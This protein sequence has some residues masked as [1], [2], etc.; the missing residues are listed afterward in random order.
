MG[1]QRGLGRGRI[2]ALVALEFYVLAWFA[3]LFV[4]RLAHHGNA[5]RP[6]LRLATGNGR[7]VFVALVIVAATALASTA[8]RAR[9]CPQRLG[10]TAMV[11]AGAAGLVAVLGMLSIGPVVAPVAVLMVLIA[12][13]LREPDASGAGRDRLWAPPPPARL[14]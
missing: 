2:V 8:W 1:A 13:P 3:A 12:L 10:V 4:L 5:H 6:E 14:S 11:V 7:I 9:R